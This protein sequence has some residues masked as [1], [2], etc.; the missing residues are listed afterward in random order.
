MAVA[1]HDGTGS[2]K[3]GDADPDV[4]G[5]GL[6]DRDEPGA[7]GAVEAHDGLTRLVDDGDAAEPGLQVGGPGGGDAPGEDGEADERG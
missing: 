6:S 1:E 7:C 2:V 5:A 3:V 4:A